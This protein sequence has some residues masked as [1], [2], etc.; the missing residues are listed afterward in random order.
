MRAPL[1]A[2]MQDE[3]DPRGTAAPEP[4]PVSVGPAPQRVVVGGFLMGLANL[5][6]GVSGGT[7]ILALGLYDRF[8]GAIADITRLRREPRSIVFLGLIGKRSRSSGRCV[9]PFA[10]G[11]LF[12]SRIA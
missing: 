11:A 1:T 2:A 9:F 4:T 3:H 6:P 12:R 10:D 5:V 8:I 7:M